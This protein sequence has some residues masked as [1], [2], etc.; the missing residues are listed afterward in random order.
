MN[1]KT[2]ISTVAIEAPCIYLVSFMWLATGAYSEHS[3]QSGTNCFPVPSVGSYCSEHK[4]LEGIAFINWIQLMLYANTLMTVATICHVRKHRMWLRRVTELPTFSAPALT[5]DP[6]PDVEFDSV[7]VAKTNDSRLPILG[8]PL[9]SVDS[10]SPHQFRSRIAFPPTD[11]PARSR[12][13]LSASSSPPIPFSESTTSLVPTVATQPDAETPQNTS[14]YSRP[15]MDHHTHATG[16][17][18]TY[19]GPGST[20]ELVTV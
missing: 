18:P 11:P 8:D 20:Y 15:D 17:P 16:E 12:I 9:Q 5:F 19:S 1:P 2:F 10:H 6:R 3:I 7:F 14:S 13:R 4:V